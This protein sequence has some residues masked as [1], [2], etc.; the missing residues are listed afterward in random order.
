MTSVNQNNNVAPPSRKS[1]P[2]PV[3]LLAAKHSIAEWVMKFDILDSATKGFK[4]ITETLMILPY[5]IR[6]HV[7]GCTW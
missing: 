6:S 7:K 4:L 1:Q 3:T 5:S 2:F